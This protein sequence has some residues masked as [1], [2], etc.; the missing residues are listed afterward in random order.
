MTTSRL[1]VDPGALKLIDTE[2]FI[3]C[4]D[5]QAAF[6]AYQHPH[7]NSPDDVKRIR[8]NRE[9]LLRQCRASTDT[10]T[11]S[12]HRPNFELSLQGFM[13]EGHILSPVNTDKMYVHHPL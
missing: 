5:H 7:I 2:G 3:E 11:R 12:A 6:P 10:H 9:S 1:Y 4:V 13:E 8:Q